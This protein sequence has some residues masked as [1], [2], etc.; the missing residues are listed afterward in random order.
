MLASVVRARVCEFGY[1][2]RFAWQDVVEMRFVSQVLRAVCGGAGA[3]ARRPH[4]A[5]QGDYHLREG[6]AH[7]YYAVYLV[8][9]IRLPILRPFAMRVYRLRKSAEP[10]KPPY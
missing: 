4:H 5:A 1:A 2:D 10:Y 7:S 9:D 3:P 8:G 6:T